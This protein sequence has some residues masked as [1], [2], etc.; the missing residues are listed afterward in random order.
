MAATEPRRDGRTPLVAVSHWRPGTGFTRV[1]ESLFARL[2]DAYRVHWVGIGYDGMAMERD[3]YRLHPA[4]PRGGDPYGAYN[5]AALALEV[6]APLALLLNDL[7]LL[8]NYPAAFQARA[9]RVRTIAYL[10]LDGEVVDDRWMAPLASLDRLVAYTRFGRDQAQAS[11]DRLGAAGTRVACGPVRVIPHGVD[12]AVFGARQLDALLVPGGRAA[13]RRR[14][15]GELDQQ[16]WVVLNANRPN[17]RKRLELTVEGFARF[18]AG[19]PAQVRLCLHAAAGTDAERTALMELAAHHGV[20]ERVWVTGAGEPLDDARLASLYRACE[21]GINTSMGEGWGLVSL[22][23]A[24]AGAAQLVPDH[25]ACAELWTDAAELLPTEPAPSQP[26][27]PLAM[28]Q[29]SAAAVAAALERLY[30]DRA[31]L[32][33]MSRAAHARATDSRLGWDAVAEQWRVLLGAEV[34]RAQTHH[35]PIPVP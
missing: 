9:P 4:N 13:A 26:W 1:L 30:A 12:H 11:L 3:G 25:S 32:E 2:Q 24:A 18:A 7:W 14:S 16:P 19:K 6:G 8:G 33:A 22:E 29:T 35:H 28:R 10:P 31:R 20:A 34:R 23:H 5:A 15:F 21:V 27:T 17:P